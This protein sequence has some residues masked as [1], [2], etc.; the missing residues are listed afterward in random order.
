MNHGQ[1]YLATKLVDA[2]HQDFG[3]FHP[4]YR[5]VHASGR[6]YAA[7]FCATP[8]AKK[9]SHALHFQ[10]DAVPVTVRHSNSRSGNPLGPATTVSM[11]VRFYLADGTSTDL[12]ALAIP[13]FVARTPDETLDFLTA[14]KPDPTTGKP[15]GAKV[16]ALLQERPWIAHA[17][18]LAKGLPSAVSFSQTTFHMLH[19]FRFVNDEGTFRYARYH[20]EPEVGGP[21]QTLE[22]LQ[23]RPPNYLFEEYEERLRS[24]PVV[25]NL[26]LQ[27][28]G[29]GDP[30][31][32]PS[33]P[34][35]DDRERLVVGK[36]TVSRPTSV[37][38]IGDAVMMHDP[39]KVTDGIEL[40]DDPILA[41]RRGIYEQSVAYRT[42][43]WKGRQAAWE[44]GGI[45]PF[46]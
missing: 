19:A 12:V 17:V 25:F 40:S 13:L 16:T 23:R 21:G 37:E 42:G 24:A 45:C 28:A 1:F 26:V 46:G 3:G 30:L 11:S 44:R 15:D 31:D 18:K 14:I 4:G 2:I 8:E 43:G 29:E 33:A 41:A 36:L 5:D 22:E 39:T 20:W 9:V 32:D 35:P 6:Y 7:S 38:E 27:F 10:G 34:W